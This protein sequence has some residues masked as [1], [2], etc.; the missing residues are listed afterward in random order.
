MGKKKS[1]IESWDEVGILLKEMA[2]NQVYVNRLE[3][4]M[5]SEITD[6]KERY[7][8]MSRE[9]LERISVIKEEILLFVSEHK[10]EFTEVKSRE[11]TFGKVGLRKSTE[12]VTRNVKAIMEALKAHGMNDCINVKESINKDVLKNYSDEKIESVGAHRKESERAY[13]EVNL[14]KLRKE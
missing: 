14:E 12:I 6:V 3:A 7:N 8:G 11:F 2:D 13:C 9:S 5:N 1:S 4:K 10:K